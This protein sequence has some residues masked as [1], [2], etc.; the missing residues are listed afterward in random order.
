M[1]V[2]VSITGSASGVV[3]VWIVLSVVAVVVARS[4]KWLLCVHEHVRVAMGGSCG[5]VMTHVDRHNGTVV[6][7]VVSTPEELS[8]GTPGGPAGGPR[9]SGASWIRGSV[10][11]GRCGGE[12]AG[13]MACI[14]YSCSIF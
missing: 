5:G 4:T 6:Q 7:G 8:R 12:G 2:A 1:P 3:G 10:T 11:A 9:G 14:L 13:E